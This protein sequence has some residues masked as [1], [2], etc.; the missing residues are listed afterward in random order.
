MMQQYK[1]MMFSESNLND[2]LRPIG[3]E[4][5]MLP[6]LDVGPGSYEIPVLTGKNKHLLSNMKDLPSFSMSSKIDNKRK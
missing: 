3:K 6:Y 5:W 2:V 4:G 1:D